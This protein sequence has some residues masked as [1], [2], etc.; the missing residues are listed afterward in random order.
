LSRRAASSPSPSP[1]GEGRPATSSVE[2]G[3][4]RFRPGF[5]GET[6]C[7]VPYPNALD[8]LT[9]TA[10]RAPSKFLLSGFAFLG[11]RGA[12]VVTI[13]S[14][15]RVPSRLADQSGPLFAKVSGPDS[16]RPQ[17][18]SPTLPGNFFCSRRGSFHQRPRLCRPRP[19]RDR[20]ERSG[21]QSARR[22]ALACQE[23]L[24]PLSHKSPIGPRSVSRNPGSAG[25]MLIEDVLGS[26][27]Y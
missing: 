11:V 20:A 10:P 27:G 12:W 19:P 7:P 26:D 4:G 17:S 5:L 2:S 23:P 3:G 14:C 24:T 1:L 8:S 18:G 15:P 16:D 25:R 13:W 9:T 22:R 6:T 21:A